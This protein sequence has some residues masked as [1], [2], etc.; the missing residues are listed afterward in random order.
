[1]HFIAES[2]INVV[3]I[4]TIVFCFGHMLVYRVRPEKHQRVRFVDL[5]REQQQRRSKIS[6]HCWR[7][8]RLRWASKRPQEAGRRSGWQRKWGPTSLRCGKLCRCDQS[9]RQS[10]GRLVG[11]SLAGPRLHSYMPMQ[12]N[13]AC[14]TNIRHCSR[15]FAFF[16]Q[17]F[18]SFFDHETVP[19][20]LLYLKSYCTD[21]L[22]WSQRRAAWGGYSHTAHWHCEHRWWWR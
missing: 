19:C 18:A 10:V 14:P 2:E 17:P 12:D 5:L 4:I 11:W 6:L 13:I 15:L 16:M 7:R 3:G 9:V 20:I 22:R 21:P 8:A 1:M